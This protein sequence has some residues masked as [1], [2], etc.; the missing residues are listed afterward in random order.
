[1]T[2]VDWRMEEV[3]R[4]GRM[5]RWGRSLFS[6]FVVVPLS[7]RLSLAHLVENLHELMVGAACLA[8]CQGSGPYWSVGER[9]ASPILCTLAEYW[10][11]VMQGGCLVLS[12]R[13]TSNSRG[14]SPAPPLLERKE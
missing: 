3:D 13:K 11:P 6:G 2:S 5:C 7:S 1:M 4:V 9:L 12:C 8:T 14:K 10:L